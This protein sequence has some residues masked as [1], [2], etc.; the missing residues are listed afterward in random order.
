MI[1]TY[2]LLA[3]TVL[4]ILKLLLS[5]SF[6]EALLFLDALTN[7]AVLYLVI[8]SISQS[9]PYWVDVAIILAMFSFVGVMSIARYTVDKNE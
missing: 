2:L 8:L 9:R 1:Y 6:A 3:T 7:I 4:L 5:K